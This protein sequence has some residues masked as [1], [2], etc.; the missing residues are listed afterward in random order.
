MNDAR[1]NEK[2]EYSACFNKP[3]RC[4]FD[5]LPLNSSF[6]GQVAYFG[7]YHYTPRDSGEG[8]QAPSVARI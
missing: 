7:G 4:K 1:Q 3:S 8:A 6:C 5:Y 2:I